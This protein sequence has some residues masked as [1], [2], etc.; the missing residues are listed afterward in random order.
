MT[1]LPF[2]SLEIQP[3]Y[4]NN[5]SFIT[6]DICVTNIFLFSPTQQ[7]NISRNYHSIRFKPDQF[8]S[9]LTTEVGFTSFEYIGAPKCSVRGKYA[10]FFCTA[11]SLDIIQHFS[12]SC[13]SLL[14]FLS[15]PDR[16]SEANLCISQ[17]T[18]PALN[19]IECE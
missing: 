13:S 16:F 9:Y 1:G 11:D 10:I 14:F 15:H 18:A 7:D 8:S 19:I 2:A 6:L 3:E 5:C 17:M 12:L 4:K